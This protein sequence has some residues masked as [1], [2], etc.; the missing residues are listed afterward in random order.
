MIPPCTKN[1]LYLGRNLEDVN[2]FFAL[3]LF[4]CGSG[5]VIQIS[6]ISPGAKKERMCSILVRRKPTFFRPILIASEAPFHIRA[7]FISTPRKFTRIALGKTNCVFTFAATQFKNNWV[8]VPE[9]IFIP[10]TL[11]PVILI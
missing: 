2:L 10:V 4:S 11:K 7:P 6:E 3:I 8:I 1:C 9:K 5:K